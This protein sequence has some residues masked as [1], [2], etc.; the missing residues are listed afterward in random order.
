MAVPRMAANQGEMLRAVQLYQ[1][2]RMRSTHASM[3]ATPTQRPLC[4]FFL[5][6]LYGPREIGSSR[7]A[8]LRS[9]VDML[10]PIL[11]RWIHDGSIGLIELHALSERVDDRLARMLRSRGRSTSFSTEEFESAYRACDDYDDRM[12]QIAL[13]A[14]S[15]RFGHRLAWDPSIARLFRLAH[16]LRGLPRLEALLAMLERGFRAFRRA[17]DIAPF[18][19]AMRMGETSYLSGVY[20]RHRS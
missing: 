5:A 15:T 17:Q 3:I 12:M 10:K 13:F 16:G 9:L 11:P 6:D 7:A 2:E 18:I 4:E 8:A 1:V 14:G 20:A 19:E